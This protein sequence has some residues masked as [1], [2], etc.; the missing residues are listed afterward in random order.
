MWWLIYLISVD[1]LQQQQQQKTSNKSN[2]INFNVSVDNNVKV[3]L[4]NIPRFSTKFSYNDSYVEQDQQ[5][6]NEIN[7]FL[8]Y[9]FQTMWDHIFFVVEITKQKMCT[10]LRV[11]KLK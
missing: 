2:S 9:S 1:I 6:Q 11:L 3:D 5:T 8:F 10:R 4:L 7:N